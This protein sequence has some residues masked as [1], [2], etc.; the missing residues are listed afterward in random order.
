[1]AGKHAVECRQRLDVRCATVNQ[2]MRPPCSARDPMAFRFTD[3][4]GR[5]TRSVRDDIPK[6]RFCIWPA[7]PLT[8]AT[9]GAT[10]GKMIMAM[11]KTMKYAG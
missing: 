1:M 11:A 8:T 3:R 6:G 4:P 5:G 9:V 10:K 2:E 7:Y